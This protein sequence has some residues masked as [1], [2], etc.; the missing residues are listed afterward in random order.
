MQ[1]IGPRVF[2]NSVNDGAHECKEDENG[3]K[4]SS[5]RGCNMTRYGRIWIVYSRLYDKYTVGSQWGSG[6]QDQ[7]LLS[8]TPTPSSSSS[9]ASQFSPLSVASAAFMCASM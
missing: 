8:T 9:S 3:L 5:D 6:D 1:D 2:I 4:V 7:D